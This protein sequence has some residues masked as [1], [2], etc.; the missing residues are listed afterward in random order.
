M[1]KILITGATGYIGRFLTTRLIKEGYALSLLTRDTS[2]VPNE[3]KA[4]GCKVYQGDIA[5][6]KILKNIEKVDA[7]FHLAADINIHGNQDNLW[8]INVEGTR[9]ILDFSLRCGVRK[10][11]LASSIEA[12]GCASLEELPINETFPPRPKNPYGQSKFEA[13][14]V[15]NAYH[16]KEGLNTV[17]ARIGTVYG[18]GTPFIFPI[19]QFLVGKDKFSQ[20]LYPFEDRYIHLVYITDVIEMLIKSYLMSQAIGKTYFFVGNEYIKFRELSKLIASL[21]GKDLIFVDEKETN[22]KRSSHMAYSNEKI[23]EE[24]DLSPIVGIKEGI[25]KTIDWFF[26]NG[27][28]PIKVGFKQKLKIFLRPF[29]K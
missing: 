19:V 28:L 10:F 17:I 8:K 3:L 6:K 20:N 7:V 13:E 9:N 18:L 22:E 12:V 29:I 23:K 21:I 1:E 27:Y 15:V 2:N 25:E 24:L 26:Q 16:K 4:K 14:K 11:I 5:D